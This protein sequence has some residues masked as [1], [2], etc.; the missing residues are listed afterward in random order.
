[1][2]RDDPKREPGEFSQS[3]APTEKRRLTDQ[4]KE[5]II[6]DGLADAWGHVIE[7]WEERRRKE[8]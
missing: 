6:L 7:C 5:E 8:P 4:E 1:M 2:Y 3:F